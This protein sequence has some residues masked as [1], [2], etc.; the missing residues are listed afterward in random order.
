MGG[1]TAVPESDRS[2]RRSDP[3]LH[4]EWHRRAYSAP[5]PADQLSVPAQQRLRA[6]QEGP[7]GRTR[8]HAAEGAE[9]Q[10]VG[11]LEAGQ[12]DMAFEDAELVAAS[13]FRQ[14]TGRSS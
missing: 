9:E 8:K 10:A 4:L 14:R 12:M 11:R 5:P 7:P 13:V 1:P 2:G 3:T 6:D